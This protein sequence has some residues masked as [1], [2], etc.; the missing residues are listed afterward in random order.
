MGIERVALVIDGGEAPE[1]AH[2]VAVRE[3]VAEWQARNPFPK[4]GARCCPAC[5]EAFKAD[6]EPGIHTIEDGHCTIAVPGRCSVGFFLDRE[7]LAF[8]VAGVGLATISISTW[9]AASLFV[10]SARLGFLDMFWIMTIGI[11]E[12][13]YFA[14]LSPDLPYGD[15]WYYFPF[16]S[17][18][19][20]FCSNRM[21]AHRL[22]Y[23]L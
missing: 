3:C 1:T 22:G 6:D 12:Y 2:S 4:V 23:C 7:R 5:G 19:H 14:I 15:Y 10:A 9:N 21:I 20:A 13:G 18:L 8:W 11:V 16:I 17:A